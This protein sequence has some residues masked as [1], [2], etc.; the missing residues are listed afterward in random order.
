M[1]CNFCGMEL[2]KK[3]AVCPNCGAQNTVEISTE[4]THRRLEALTVLFFVLSIVFFIAGAVLKNYIGDAQQVSM[5][6][7]EI[8]TLMQTYGEDSRFNYYE[9][10]RET[11][12]EFI[13][14]WDVKELP[15]YY[16][17]NYIVYYGHRAM[18]DENLPEQY[19]EQVALELEAILLDIVGISQEEYA[20]LFDVDPEYTYA[21]RMPEESERKLTNAIATKLG[22]EIPED[23]R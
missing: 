1:R 19:R 13:D 4:N 10:F 8:A 7:G 14:E 15:S 22:V 9:N 23:R 6:Q 3:Q 18:H 2:P 21:V 5:A 16:T 20:L 12:N 11:A 17:L